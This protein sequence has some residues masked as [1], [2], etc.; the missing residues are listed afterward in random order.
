M[1]TA[2]VRRACL[3]LPTHRECAATITA[4]AAEA[5]YG[6]AT[7]G[8]EMTLLIL[9]SC[10]PE[11]YAG[12]VAAVRDLPEMP[13]VAVLHLDEPAQSRFLDRVIAGA[14]VAKPELTAELMLPDR[15]SYGACT[16]RA[17]LIA[18]AL[19]CESVHRRDSD[20]SFQ[21]HDGAPLYPIHHELA[22]IGRPAADV[23]AETTEVAL[24]PRHL[25]K[26]VVSVGG[27]FLGDLSVDIQEI[28]D[29]DPRAYHEI[30]SLWAPPGA[31]EQEKAELVAES[32]TGAPDGEFREDRSVLALVD[33]MRVDMANISYF[34]VHE[35]V[36]LPPMNDT[37]GSD[38]F[39]IHLV[40]ESTLPG[41]L[42]NRHVV[43]FHTPDRKADAAFLDYHLRLVKFF[44]S[45][46]YLHFVYARMH[47]AGERLLDE[48][49]RVR[50]PMLAAMVRESTGLDTA[51]NVR[52][53]D[54]LERTYRRLD[55]RFARVADRLADGRELL[56]VQARQD[57]EDF[58]LLIEVWEPLIRSAR[59]CGPV[60]LR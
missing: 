53:L 55:G 50:A 23:A 10:D 11:T 48:R 33:P 40:P 30:V 59:A 29:R 57:I 16:N 4:V 38:Y 7:F 22:A 14:G 2:G 39:H 54:Q 36:P 6:A 24:D 37:I 12:H 60:G 19:G 5:A 13:G 28:R 46:L 8:V 42:H 49:H 17:F 26:P 41:V 51:P 43:N 20:A 31:T 44:L 35:D 27:S 45:M 18:A 15:V 58:A 21:H 56:I 47:A 25:D 1:V 34:Q 52:V 9:D 32:F 3:A